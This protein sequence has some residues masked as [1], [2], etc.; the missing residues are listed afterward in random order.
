MNHLKSFIYFNSTTNNTANKLGCYARFKDP[1]WLPCL[2]DGVVSGEVYW[3]CRDDVDCSLNGKCLSNGTCSC[4]PAWKGWRCQLLNILPAPTN[5]GYK[6]YATSSWGGT[7]L[8]NTVDD[9]F[10]MFLSYFPNYCGHTADTMNSHVAHAI[11]TSSHEG[12]YKVIG[13]LAQEWSHEPFAV[14]FLFIYII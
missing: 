14:K 11:S 2:A 6:G 13:Q 10:H 8:R 9:S 3:P 12:P 1:L 5:G 4:R 7:V